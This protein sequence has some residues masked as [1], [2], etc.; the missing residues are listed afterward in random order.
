MTMT[1]TTTTTWKRPVPPKGAAEASFWKYLAG[2]ASATDYKALNESLDPAGGFLVPPSF[3]EALLARLPEASF[4][5]S[6]ADVRTTTSDTLEVPTVQ[7][8]ASFPS[9]FSGGFLV[10]AV[11]ETPAS[12]ADYPMAF[13]SLGV[14]IRKFGAISRISNDLLND[15]RWAVLEL[16]NLAARDLGAVL[17]KE[18]L[19]GDGSSLH[20]QGILNTAG[21]ATIGLGN[22]VGPPSVAGWLALKRALPS[23]YWPNATVFMSSSMRAAWETVLESLSTSN[24]AFGRTP[25]GGFT[26]DLFPMILSDWLPPAN[27]QGPAVILG[28]LRQAYVVARNTE[29]S[30]KVISESTAADR[31]QS[32]LI[33]FARY[34]GA[35]KNTD[36]VRIGLVEW[37]PRRQPCSRAIPSPGPGWACPT[38]TIGPMTTRG[39]SK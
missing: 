37:A 33:F 34:G 11:G 38:L 24:L 15:A 12:G 36:A 26:F 39:A 2:K 4:A 9:M 21:I 25:T 31:D 32:D 17:N 20:F 8:N 28:E 13:G 3:Q 30:V 7:P 19:V 35:V 29:F 27:V 18:L 5:L 22:A 10:S 1:T 6:L 14:G 16:A 23:Q